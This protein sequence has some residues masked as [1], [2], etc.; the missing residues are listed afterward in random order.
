V[1]ALCTFASMPRYSA[2]RAD[3][4][5]GLDGYAAA[6]TAVRS[7]KMGRKPAHW[8]RVDRDYELI[9]IDMQALLNDPVI[10]TPPAA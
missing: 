1:H 10:E 4:K 8:T 7:P 9:R 3:A 6:G 5:L 2:A